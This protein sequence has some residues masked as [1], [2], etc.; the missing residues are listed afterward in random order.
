MARAVK[1]ETFIPFI[2]EGRQYIRFVAKELVKRPSFNSDLVIG[3]A[4]FDY[5]VLFV[6]LKTQAV[7]CFRQV[8]QSFSSGG[9][10]AR[11]LHNVSM[12]DYVEFV[13]DIRHINLDEFNCGLAIG[14]MVSFL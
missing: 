8:F 3:I 1:G 11:E 5:N 13:D 7:D 14:D 4:C 9:W 2:D 12:D 10:L 6:L